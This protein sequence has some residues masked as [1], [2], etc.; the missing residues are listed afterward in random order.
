[1]AKFNLT[2]PNVKILNNP[3]KQWM[4]LSRGNV[5]IASDRK[6]AVDWD[7]YN[8]NDYLFTHD[9][10]V[11]SVQ[12][13]ENGYYIEPPCDELVNSNGNAWIT[14]VLLATFK[15][16]IGKPNYSEHVQIPALS[17]GILLD[18]VARPVKYASDNGKT[19]SVVYIDILV[20]TDRRHADIVSRVESGELNS[21]S[22]GCCVATTTCSKCG[23]VIKEGEN[24]CKCL[25][26]HLLEY[27]VDENGVKRIIAELCGS[28]EYDEN[29]KPKK[30]AQGNFIADPNSVEFIEASW[31]E[32]PAFKGAV[33]N[34]QIED[35]RKVASNILE[36]PDLRDINFF[37]NI[38]KLRVADKFG[39]ATIKL[40]MEEMKKMKNNEMYKRIAK[41][42]S[43]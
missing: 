42:I 25:D 33:V 24:N 41:R 18:A 21:L 19:A 31:V 32:N 27:F 23:K 13:A 1:M 11:S 20:A 28:L 14:P 5:R 10:I 3:K 6:I 7:K 16:F 29:G 2:L 39:M 43:E 22:M 37:D 34:Y 8:Q 17:K 9:T 26:K 36:L 4:E 30:D 12:V 35:M 40:V 38:H 15:S